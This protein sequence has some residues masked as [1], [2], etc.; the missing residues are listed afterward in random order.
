[1]FK[2]SELKKKRKTELIDMIYNSWIYDHSHIEGLNK[3]D[4]AV[5]YIGWFWRSTHFVSKHIWIGDCGEFRGVMENN[6]WDYP[7][8][9]MTEKEADTFISYIDNSINKSDKDRNLV[10]YD[11]W[12]WFQTLKI[13]KANR[14]S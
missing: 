13:D 2:L 1:M 10:L 4:K 11:M 5:P 6:K 14:R 8:R 7:E 12:D 9:L 3:W